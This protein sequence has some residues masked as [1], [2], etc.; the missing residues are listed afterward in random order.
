MIKQY[1]KSKSILTHIIRGVIVVIVIF[2]LIPATR[3]STFALILK[4][5]L[6]IHQPKVL[7]N[8]IELSAQSNKWVLRSI[9]GTKKQLSDFN[10]KVIFINLWATWC[11]PCVA[12]IPALQNLYNHYQGQVEFLFISNESLDEINSFIKKRNVN[13][14]VY[15]PITNYPFDFETNSLPT[16]FIIDKKGNI[17]VTK[18]GAAKWDSPRVRKILDQLIKQ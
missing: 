6:F 12:E 11:A 10:G 16:T 17:A 14:P 13:L 15:Q 18:K 9:D 3:T 8:K 4:P 5:T 2:L 7:K 1:L